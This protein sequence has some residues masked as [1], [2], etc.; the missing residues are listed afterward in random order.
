M[1]CERHFI[2]NEGLEVLPVRGH[3][4]HRLLSQMQVTPRMSLQLISKSPE[5]TVTAGQHE[6]QRPDSL[7]NRIWSS[8][9]SCDKSPHIP[10]SR[11]LSEFETQSLKLVGEADK[12]L[13]IFPSWRPVLFVFGQS[14]TGRPLVSL[15]LQ[16]ILPVSLYGLSWLFPWHDDAALYYTQWWRSRL[17]IAYARPI[18]HHKIHNITKSVMTRGSA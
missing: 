4:L 12:L 3:V 17:S 15:P 6:K 18:T 2:F 7:K 11:H 10:V 13:S 1:L 9:S 5:Q 14:P 8:Q 16:F